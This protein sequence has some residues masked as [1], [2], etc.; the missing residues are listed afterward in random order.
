M[1]LQLAGS[2][3]TK[4]TSRVHV[5]KQARR[6]TVAVALLAAI[7]ILFAGNSQAVP[8]WSFNLTAS[9]PTGVVGVP[10]SGV[11]VATGGTA[12]YK[13]A[14]TDGSLPPGLALNSTTGAITGTPSAPF[15]KFFRIKATDANGKFANIHSQI[16]VVASSSS[17]V[18]IT[19]SPMSASLASGSSQ[20]F[21]AVV[22]GSS[23]KG[24]TWTSTA[25][26]VSNG[27]LFTAPNV[28]SSTNVM[29]TATSAA[30]STKKATAIVAVAAPGISITVSPTSA[31]LTSG[32][33]K[34][35][36]ARVQ[37]TTNTSVTWSASAGTVSS[38]GLFTAPTV[39]TATNVTV[40]ATSS[41]NTANKASAT[42]AVSPAG[43]TISVT[44]SPTSTTLTSGNTKQFSA[45]VQGTSNTAV[46]WSAS[47]GTVSSSGLFT[48]PNVTNS[49]SATVTA[50]SNADT[51][52]KSSA[53]VAVNPPASVFNITTSAV[54]G[55]QSGSAYS[56][57]LSAAGGTTP[58]QWN[59]A[60]GSLPQGFVLSSSGQLS[61]TT[62][63]TGQF[64]FTAQATDAG[65]STASKSFSLSVSAPPPPPSSGSYDGPARLPVTY[66]QTALA[67]TP[68]PGTTTVVSAGGNLQNALNSANCGDTIALAAGATFS[69]M[70]TLPAKPCDNSHWI[71]IRTSAPN[72]ALPPE[73]SRMLPCYAG[74]ASLPGRPSFGC[75]S[76]QNVLAK[77]VFNSV[78]SGPFQ[79]ANGANHYR[80]IGL[81]IARGSGTGLVGA[82]VGTAI[83]ASA[84]HIILDRVWLHGSTQDETMNAFNV[85][86][87]SYAALI[88]SYTTDFHCTSVSGACTDAHVFF[89]GASSTTDAVYKVTG[90]FLEGS[91]ENILFGGGS[92]TT[93]PT[94][95]EIRRNHFF[96]PMTWMSGQPGYV[97]GSGGYPFMV[98][99][100][101]EL[102]N[103]ARVLI[104]GNIFEN[105]WGGFSQVGYSILLTPKNQASA[106]SVGLCPT[107]AVT[108]VTIRYNTISHVGAGIS[109]ANVTSAAGPALYGERYS[110]HD[111][112]IDDISVAKYK[113]SGT[114][115]MVL[116][117]WVA[118][119]LNN[120]SVN[121]ITGFPDPGSRIIDL[122]NNIADPPMYAFKFTNNIVG[123]VQYP[124][125]STGGSTSN[126]AYYDVPLPS[127]NS[128]FT[129]YT[130]IDN[131][132]VAS[133]NFPASK[134][135]ASNYFPAT[136]GGMQFVNFNGG[137]GG[138]YHLLSSSP[139]KNAASDG[140]DIGA[141]INAIQSMIAGV[142]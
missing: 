10:Y 64:S 8:A 76:V 112:T 102:K 44:V 113:G 74:V 120:V 96:K 75:S 54:P 121:H 20:Q 90:N 60:S 7:P 22:S 59:I 140:K 72:S 104:E 124:I 25:G 38:S 142:Y 37:G 47:G 26:S 70:F 93:T 77:V 118:N 39:S 89:G 52:K 106:T 130:F 36:A 101:L 31:S 122:G 27:G 14:L 119:S 12:P 18:S 132:I 30:D 62:T 16:T 135:P 98:K 131:A 92:A 58:Y 100:H 80:F 115:L 79:L 116:S 43:S 23:N 138:D 109:I 88:D 4:N 9:L 34:Q 136:I 51:T 141:D 108:D 45:T 56:F 127:L 137:N 17:T 117:G 105:S 81:E 11:L 48:A 15:T 139:Y 65:N 53:T 61:G 97:G 114:L 49:T 99:N 33:T 125:W 84:D 40:T 134:W 111:V 67:N 82:L 29:V 91:T 78:G 57:P 103:A 21:S 73:G 6:Y 86:R 5:F 107:C 94:D 63:Q 95:I 28:S 42:V 71:I 19:V 133:A 68:G 2:G 69:G 85:N 3:K 123:Q 110:I 1:A 129:A 83:G 55:A 126:C 35:F 32:N 24:V 87:M 41:A 66:M 50:T 46:S 13:F 128:C